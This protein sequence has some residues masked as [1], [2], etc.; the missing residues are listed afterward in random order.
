MRRL[1]YRV[2]ADHQALVS[3]QID[4]IHYQRLAIAAPLLTLLG[5]VFVALDLVLLER[6]GPS[7]LVWVYTVEDV[8]FVL[9]HLGFLARLYRGPRTLSLPLAFTY[10]GFILAWGA[11]AG[12]V[13]F[14]RTGG[15]N[16]LFLAMV[17]VGALGLFSARASL[18]L[19]LATMAGFLGLNGFW[20]GSHDIFLEKYFP[21]WAI[22]ILAFA[23]SQTLYA[24]VVQNLVAQNNLERANADLK[25]ARLNLIQQDKMASLGGLAAGLAHELSGPLETVQKSLATL[26]TRLTDPEAAPAVAE[27]QE[28][29]G[30][31]SSVL[32]A[33]ESFSREVPGGRK[34][35]YDLNEGI[36]TSLVMVRSEGVSD[37]VLDTD[38]ADLP[39]FPALGPEINQVLLSL[40]KNA[41]QAV[42]TQPEGPVKLVLVRTR[43]EEGYAVA[44]VVNTGPPVPGHLRER[45][46]DPFFSTKAPGA[47]AGLGL[48]LG[49]QTIV[50]RH[51]GELE[52][53]DREPVTFRIRLPLEPRSPGPEG[54]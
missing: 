30:Q 33:L 40:L 23:V 3:R 18:V 17:G 44:E 32:R 31:V 8:V 14:L 49:W 42:R 28:G 43:R 20:S 16:T 29:L 26:E 35:P 11:S 13:E 51:G 15:F 27:A 24:A 53:L 5:L 1:L 22:P 38:L 7:P 48:S 4:E 25:E 10:V 2:P 50:H 47:G 21:L 52:L 12:N 37:V 41:V 45:I 19:I 34:S 54:S 9:V 6:E 46:F 39:R 36:R